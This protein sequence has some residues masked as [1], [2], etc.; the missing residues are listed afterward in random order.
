MKNVHTVIAICNF[1]HCSLQESLLLMFIIIL[2]ML[3]CS[4]NILLLIEEFPQNII[5]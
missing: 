4:Q 5:S 1:L 2:I 3:F